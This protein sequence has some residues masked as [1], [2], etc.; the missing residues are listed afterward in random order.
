MEVCLTL[1]K[2]QEAMESITHSSPE[3]SPVGQSVD[4]MSDKDEVVSQVK[5]ILCMSDCCG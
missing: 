3:N 5:T 1:C 4:E 2:S